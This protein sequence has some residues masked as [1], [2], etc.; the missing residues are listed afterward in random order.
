MANDRVTT[1]PSLTSNHLSRP[2]LRSLDR[3][4]GTWEMSEDVRGRVTYE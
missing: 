4:V 3:L 1:T 2:D